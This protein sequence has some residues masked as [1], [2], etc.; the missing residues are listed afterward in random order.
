MVPKS[1]TAYLL[2]H[3]ACAGLRKNQFGIVRNS[4]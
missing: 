3:P 1:E 4:A 2:I